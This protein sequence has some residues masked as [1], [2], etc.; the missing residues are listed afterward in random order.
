MPELPPWVGQPRPPRRSYPGD[1]P[2]VLIPPVRDDDQET[3]VLP[4]VPADAIGDPDR[5]RPRGGDPGG[6]SPRDLP[7]RA[8]R[9]A[10]GRPA[11]G[12]PSGEPGADTNTGGDADA[13]NGETRA[14]RRRAEPRKGGERRHPAHQKPGDGGEKVVPLRPL[15]TSDGYRSI[16]SELT[17]TTVGSVVR[18]VIRG[19]GELM[20]T[21]GVLILFFAAYEIWGSSA[22]I[23]DYQDN[24]DQQLAQEWAPESS[25]PSTPRSA[26]ETLAPPPGKA[27]A[28]LH[29]P[30]LDKHW[31]VVEGVKPDDIRYAP[32][33]YPKTAMPG[34]TGN[35]AVAGHR[36]RATFW[37][38]DKMKKGDAIVVETRTTWH[39]YKVTRNRIVLPTQVEVVGKVPPGFARGD[40]LLTLTTCNPKFDNYERLIVHAEL[41]SSIPRGEG[42]PAELEG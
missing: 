18:G 5:T 26:A 32:G 3:T 2:T 34:Q 21:F 25:S 30:R 4:A 35:F 37:D 20:I 29:V 42:P 27:V 15:R 14:G 39:V 7:L 28:R 13:R 17:R 9:P 38:L 16:Y 11:N 31:V 36:N 41:E 40:K 12:Q 10:N 33:H 8:G 6:R 24:L 23:N 22:I 1:D 19:T